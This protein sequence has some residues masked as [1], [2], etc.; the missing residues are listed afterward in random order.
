MKVGLLLCDHVRTAYLDEFGD[1]PPMFAAAW[2]SFDFEVFAVCDGE[3]PASIRDC[4][5]YLASGSRYSVYEK[6][7]WIAEL[8]TFVQ[9]VA[10]KE[11]PYLGVCFG[12]QLL[13]EALG[14]AVKKVESGWCVGTHSFEMKE[15]EDWMNPYQSS[16]NLLMMC[17]DQVQ[18]LPS[19]SKVLASAPTCPVGMFQVGDR[20][21]G[22]QAH[23][24]FSKAYDQVLME[25][26]VERMG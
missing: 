7:D 3:F 8:K 6:K 18:V 21:L 13:A 15:Q 26:R 17:Q 25:T 24:E 22:V 12:H 20:M 9:E 11:L 5:A 19:D 16:L 2:P 10:A 14:G 1:Y 23:P 4:N